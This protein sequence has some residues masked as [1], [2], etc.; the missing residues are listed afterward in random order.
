M[1]PGR[2]VELNLDSDDEE[3][4][5]TASAPPLNFDFVKDVV[6]R[7]PAAAAEAP[8]PP[9]PR[10][11]ATGF[12]EHKKR[13]PRQSR[14]KQRNAGASAAPPSAAMPAADG[15]R[16]VPE[17]SSVEEQ[18][19]LQ[20]SID[21]Q[22]ALASMSQEEIEE[23]RRELL[24]GRV[25][26]VTPSLIERLLK[27]AAVNQ[28][29]PNP[30]MPPGALG[31]EEDSIHNDG[32]SREK[33]HVEP[34]SEKPKKTVSFADPFPTSAPSGSATTPTSLPQPEFQSR[35]PPS[36]AQPQP[37]VTSKPISRDSNAAPLV[38][39]PDLRPVTSKEPLPPR[40]PLPSTHFPAAAAPPDLDPNSP[41]FL[42]DLQQ[43]YFPHLAPDP[44]S[45]SWMAPVPT[46]EA[47]SYSASASSLLPSELRFDFKGRLLPPNLSHQLPSHLGLHHHGIAPE[48]AGYTIPELSL[49]ARSSLAPQRCVA[50]Q[51]LGRILFKL[52]KGIYGPEGT[53]LY[54]GLWRCVE[55]G[56]GIDS[57]T[58][59][60]MG[61]GSDGN[62]S[63]WALATEGIWNWRM[64][65]GR[66]RVAE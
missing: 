14:F 35:P 9:Q 28:D 65:G 45:L 22:Q 49:M 66:K 59:E 34:A 36:R 57:M 47:S 25:P 15:T 32:V 44:S 30:M 27:R 55:E 5:S 53:Q 54:E 58:K 56:K 4:P 26:G 40:A 61:D 8:Q 46:P 12:P 42:T 2:R 60:A 38:P 17:S 24:S 63:A 50:Y 29:K 13:A 16:R 52:G 10:S 21:S 64:G 33:E 51:T 23:E 6:E 48:A 41:T 11:S 62:R 1:I 7:D 3:V 19:R 31:Q 18:G 43:H 37:H 20:A 39:P